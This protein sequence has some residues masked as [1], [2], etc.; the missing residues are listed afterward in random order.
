VLDASALMCLCDDMPHGPLALLHDYVPAPSRRAALWVVIWNTTTAE[1][2][3]TLTAPPN[4][5]IRVLLEGAARLPEHAFRH[6]RD[7][8]T[9]RVTSAHQAFHQVRAWLEELQDA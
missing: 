5:P 6:C 3:A 2:P 8:K 7:L 4:V 9:A 1:D